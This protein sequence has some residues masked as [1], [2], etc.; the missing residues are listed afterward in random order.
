M[1][2]WFLERHINNITVK[3]NFSNHSLYVDK[4]VIFVLHNNNFISEMGLNYIHTKNSIPTD[5]YGCRIFK[6]MIY[7]M[8]GTHTK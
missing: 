3:N 2:L 8:L 7:Q 4:P 1:Y 5:R 6:G